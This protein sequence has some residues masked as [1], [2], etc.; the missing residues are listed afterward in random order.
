MLVRAAEAA[1]SAAPQ[2]VRELFAI[3]TFFVGKERFGKGGS[4]AV[5]AAKA[6]A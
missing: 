6:R 1:R 3:S 5:E 4:A 2:A